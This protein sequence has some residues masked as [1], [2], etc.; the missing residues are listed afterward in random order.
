MRTAVGREEGTEEWL[1]N[2]HL[3]DSIFDSL[4]ILTVSKTRQNFATIPVPVCLV[5]NEPHTFKLNTQTRVF[6]Y[7]CSGH[8]RLNY[9]SFCSDSRPSVLHQRTTEHTVHTPA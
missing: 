2:D 4:H 5:S 1:S 6:V 8:G 9:N 7:L 3:S